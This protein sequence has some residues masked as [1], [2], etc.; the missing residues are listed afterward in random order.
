MVGTIS[1][2]K[3]GEAILDLLCQFHQAFNSNVLLN[4][5]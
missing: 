1:Q 2:L 4:Q 3:R 5:L